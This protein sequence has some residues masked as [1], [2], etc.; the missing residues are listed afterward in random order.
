MKK[1]REKFGLAAKAVVSSLS[2][3]ALSS[4]VVPEMPTY[5]KIARQVG[6]YISIGSL[7]EKKGAFYSGNYRNYFGSPLEF[8][9][10]D[11][12]SLAKTLM[13]NPDGVVGTLAKKRIEF[14]QNPNMKAGLDRAMKRIMPH[15]PAIKHVFKSKGVPEEL[16]LL[17][18]LESYFRNNA[19]SHKGAKGPF[20]LMDYIAE[21]H[22]MI[23]SGAEYDERKHP[24]LAAETAASELKQR[25]EQ[26][27][28]WCLAILRYN[29]GKPDSYQK[30]NESEE[31]S[32]DGYFNFLGVSLKE[33]AKRRIIV[34]KG[35]TLSRISKKFGV[36][37][38]EIVSKNNLPG[39][40]IKLG[41]ELTIPL[42]I[43]TP[44]DFYEN[45]NYLPKFLA[46]LEILRE[47]ESEF[48]KVAPSSSSL[49][50]Y[51]VPQNGNHIVSQDES[52]E[53]IARI[54]SGSNSS[55]KSVRRM[56]AGIIAANGLKRSMIKP[57]QNLV[58]PYR[59]SLEEIAEERGH[60]LERIKSANP[61]IKSSSSPLPPNAK[62]II[63]KT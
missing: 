28:D 38:E 18:L 45:I 54:Y 49:E 4:F 12:S 34:K 22:G 17:S 26:F 53:Q 56:A 7:K 10:S 9:V 27:G 31:I 11:A 40:K 1:Q 3:V 50:I 16:I 43:K 33:I 21:K 51:I 59:K 30:Q 55:Q 41:S 57:G 37:L 8:S 35:D 23:I 5:P 47:E 48:Y 42:K 32:C 24:I 20:Q 19:T 60:N 2:A 15:L 39:I 61:H 6:E 52:I 46:L 58:I 63:Y 14:Y 36:S 29:S 13:E 44:A 25:Y 62:V